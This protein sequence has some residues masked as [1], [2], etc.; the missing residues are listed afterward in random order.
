ML[1]SAHHLY[2][3]PNM[4]APHIYTK[5][6]A[7]VQSLIV[8]QSALP[9]QQ[10][11]AHDNPSLLFARTSIVVTELDPVTLIASY[12][13]HGAPLGCMHVMNRLGDITHTINTLL[14]YD[15]A[16]DTAKEPIFITP[17]T[18]ARDEIFVSEEDAHAEVGTTEQE[19]FATLVKRH[20]LHKAFDAYMLQEFGYVGKQPR[21]TLVEATLMYPFAESYSPTDLDFMAETYFEQIAIDAIHQNTDNIALADTQTMGNALEEVRHYAEVVGK[22]P[23]KN[24][25]TTSQLYAMAQHMLTE[26]V[27]MLREEFDNDLNEFI[28][29]YAPGE[30]LP[31]I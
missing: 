20:L 13:A 26:A 12:V 2:K 5:D 23:K 22:P 30:P 25:S 17:D 1:F 31:T 14:T 16:E 11:I 21:D 4:T 8:P 18:Y 19:V 24:S 27:A 15:D 7:L 29:H 6:D 10:H 9:A 3:K 28:T